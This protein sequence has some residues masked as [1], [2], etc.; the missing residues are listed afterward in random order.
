MMRHMGF[1][2]GQA[3]LPMGP[4]PA[5]VDERAPQVLANLL[6]RRGA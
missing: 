5:W 2:V 1:A 6:A 4:A 3:R